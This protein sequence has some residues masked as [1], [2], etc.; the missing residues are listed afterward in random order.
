M[1]FLSDLATDNQR[2]NAPR[3][4]VISLFF[5]CYFLVLSLLFLCFRLASLFRLY[6]VSLGYFSF[7][8]PEMLGF[9][10][11]S[12]LKNKSVFSVSQISGF[13]RFPISFLSIG[14]RSNKPPTRR[15]SKTFREP[16]PPNLSET[17]H[18][19]PSPRPLDNRQIRR[20]RKH[21]P[22]RLPICI[23]RLV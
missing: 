7:F 20:S 15:T 23:V 4:F 9:V 5:P 1:S 6:F 3:F 14:N 10:R 17:Y 12:K 22:A 11:F 19:L 18:F 21:H 2:A 8:A 16:T 13:L